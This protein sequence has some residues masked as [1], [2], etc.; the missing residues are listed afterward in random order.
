MAYEVVSLAKFELEFESIIMYLVDILGTLKAA[1][2]LIEGLE[3]MRSV[4]EVT[5]EIKAIS[6]KPSLNQHQYREYLVK[7]YVVVYR[8]D[9][10]KVLLEHIFHSKQNFE[11]YI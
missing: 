2:N 11:A 1:C 10:N 4:L 7:N 5:P 6:K 3:N 8:V 9:G